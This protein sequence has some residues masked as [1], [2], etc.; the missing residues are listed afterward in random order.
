MKSRFFIAAEVLAV[1]LGVG[2]AIAVSGDAK[3]ARPAYAASH[4]TRYAPDTDPDQYCNVDG[5]I[6]ADYITHYVAWR[7]SNLVSLNAVRSWALIYRDQYGGST[8]TA[9][10]DTGGSVGAYTASQVYSECNVEGTVGGHC[11]TT[12]HD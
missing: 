3:V 5:T 10:Y 4:C 2:L 1:A 9:G 6:D 8:Y 11:K 12:W 7:D